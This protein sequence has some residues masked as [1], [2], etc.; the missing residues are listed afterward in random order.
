MAQPLAI[1]RPPKNPPT[2][3]AELLKADPPVANAPITGEGSSVVRHKGGPGDYSDAPGAAVI[4]GFMPGVDEWHDPIIRPVPHGGVELGDQLR[5]VNPA[6]TPPEGHGGWDIPSHGSFIDV[7]TQTQALFS[8][9]WVRS[10]AAKGLSGSFTGAHVTIRRIRPGSDQ[11]YQAQQM[12]FP[13]QDR[14]LP[15]A[16]DANIIIGGGLENLFAST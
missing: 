13:N 11:G 15:T 12:T 6:K 7:S 2:T 14:A 10:T 9:D 3:A 5:V 4:A 16:W 8:S 1:Y